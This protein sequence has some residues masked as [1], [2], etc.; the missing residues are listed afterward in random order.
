MV[1]LAD[2]NGPL[3]EERPCPRKTPLYD[4]AE[5]LPEQTQTL[6]E[7]GKKEYPYGSTGP[8]FC[9]GRRSFHRHLQ[10]TLLMICLDYFHL[11]RCQHSGNG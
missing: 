4:T 3:Q 6:K 11:A 7:M 2:A 10:I 1:S 9:H 8:L 5:R